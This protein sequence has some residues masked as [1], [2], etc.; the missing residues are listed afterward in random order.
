[1]MILRHSLDITDYQE[2]V[3]P[4]RGEMLSVAQSRSFPSEQIDLWTLDFG[5]GDQHFAAIYVIGTGNPMPTELHGGDGNFNY[6]GTWRKFLGTVVTPVG[7]VW[8]VF[9]GPARPTGPC[10]CEVTYQSHGFPGP[11]QHEDAVPYPCTDSDCPCRKWQAP[12]PAV[13]G[14][15]GN[16]Q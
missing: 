6:A 14:R 15:Q 1:M 5:T 4:G 3:L 12:N 9:H 10:Q 16:A 11:H 13:L 8:H 2:I 7:L